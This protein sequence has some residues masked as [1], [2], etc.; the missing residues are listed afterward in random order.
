MPSRITAFLMLLSTLVFQVN[1]YALDTKPSVNVVLTNE[2]N[3]PI[4]L[5]TVNL[6]I[7]VQLEDAG[8]RT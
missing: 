5:S 8:L 6:H 1:C 7:P 3:M 4:H 2:T